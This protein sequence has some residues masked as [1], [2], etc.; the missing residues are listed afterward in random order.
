[1]SDRHGV[2][3]RVA[4]ETRQEYVQRCMAWIRQRIEG[5]GKRPAGREWAQRLLDRYADGE[6]L[7]DLSVRWACEATGQD[8]QTIRAMV[9]ADRQRSRQRVVL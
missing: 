6:A 9:V 1:M 8:E 7:P 4:G 3:P 5:V 2:G